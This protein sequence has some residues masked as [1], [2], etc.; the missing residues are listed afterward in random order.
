LRHHS[1][2]PIRPLADL[3]E[4][5]DV[6]GRRIERERRADRR[7]YLRQ[8]PAEE[9]SGGFAH[10]NRLEAG[11]RQLAHRLAVAHRRDERM[12]IVSGCAATESSR[13]HRTVE[14]DELAA[15][16]EKCEQRREI[17]VSDERLPRAACLIAIEERQQLDAAVPAT[18]A[19][20]TGYRFVAPRGLN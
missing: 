3:I 11:R 9:R 15:D 7:Q 10:T 16:R 12:T 8:R 1:M 18:D 17:A 2:E 5:Q 20:H 13:Q 19:N 14:R 6:A 4:K